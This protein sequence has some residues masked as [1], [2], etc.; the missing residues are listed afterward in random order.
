MWA[1]AQSWCWCWC[2]VVLLVC[3]PPL[4][5]LPLVHPSAATPQWLDL[6][7]PLDNTSHHWPGFLGFNL[8]LMIN[9][10]VTPDVWAALHNFASS[11]HTGTHMDAPIHVGRDGTWSVDQIPADRLVGHAA[12][13]DIADRCQADPDS[14]LTTDDLAEWRK[15]H[16][17]FVYPTILLVR[18]GQ[19]AHRDNINRYLGLPEGYQFQ[20]D[21]FSF[22][23]HELPPLRFPGI[24]KAAA[25]ELAADDAV[26]GVGVDCLSLDQSANLRL[27][28]HHALFARNKFG[29]ENVADLSRVPATGATVMALPMKIRGGTGG[30]ARILVRLPE[31]GSQS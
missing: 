26:V 21:G 18:T 10:S 30:P 11:E 29:L 28:A 27:E 9:G 6:S 23:P 15:Q 1:G 31:E 3:A 13:I 12:M 19:A 8:T 24:G 14:I 17:Q 22:S 20:E 7:H 5:A 25:D 16:G 2:S 4:E